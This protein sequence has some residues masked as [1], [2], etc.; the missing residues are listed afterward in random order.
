M[1]EK[2]ID[3]KRLSD[4]AIMAIVMALQNALAEQEDITKTLRN[5]S[6]VESEEGLVVNNPPRVKIEDEVP[7]EDLI[8]DPDE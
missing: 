1:S 4:Q 3:Y 2:Q 8:I 7:E 5:F 6:L